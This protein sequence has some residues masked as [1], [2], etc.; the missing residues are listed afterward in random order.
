MVVGILKSGGVLPALELGYLHRIDSTLPS[1]RH[2]IPSSLYLC[3]EDDPQTHLK[4]FQE[5]ED[6]GVF[7]H[8]TSTPLNIES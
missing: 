1:F 7:P 3:E 6:R 2:M 8:L 5:L 4:A